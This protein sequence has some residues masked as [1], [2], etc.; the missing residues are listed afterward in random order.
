MGSKGN[1]QG[2]SF[3]GIPTD[4]LRPGDWQCNKCHEYMFARAPKCKW[5]LAAKPKHP[6]I[7]AAAG[8]TD[9]KPPKVNQ[10]QGPSKVAPHQ[11]T[12]RWRQGGPHQQQ[13]PPPKGAKE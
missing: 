6:K 1:A 5:C 8:T 9:T 11:P 13:Q 2:K 10:P 4:R 7:W 12:G 3:T